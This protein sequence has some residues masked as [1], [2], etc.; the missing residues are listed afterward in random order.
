[1]TVAYLYAVL[2]TEKGTLHMHFFIY[3]SGKDYGPGFIDTETKMW[4]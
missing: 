3:H 2:E 1:M 4:K